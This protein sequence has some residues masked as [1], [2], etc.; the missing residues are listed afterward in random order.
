M[1]RIQKSNQSQTT[2][3]NLDQESSEERVVQL[4]QEK[5]PSKVEEVEE[6]FE[7]NKVAINLRNLPKD[8]GRNEK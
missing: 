8:S 1:L 6:G 4:F 2:D 3:E 5:R 7:E